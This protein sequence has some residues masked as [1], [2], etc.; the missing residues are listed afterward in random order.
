M[1]AAAHHR[2]DLTAHIAVNSPHR[3]LVLAQAQAEPAARAYRRTH[4]SL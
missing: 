1:R 3:L 4:R 2:G